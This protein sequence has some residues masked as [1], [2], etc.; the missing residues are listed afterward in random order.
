MD[1]LLAQFLIE[2]P[3][4]V[5]QGG[6]ALLALEKTPND[7]AQLDDAFRAVHTLKGSVGL[8][9]LPAMEAA[10]HA[11]EDVLSAIRE[12]R[13]M[14]DASTVG[15]LLAVLAQTERWIDALRGGGRLPADA[16]AVSAALVRRFADAEDEAGPTGAPT[17]SATPDWA[18]ALR[19]ALPESTSPGPLTALRYLPSADSYFSGDDP[20]ALLQAA[21]NLIHL[22]LGLRPEAAPG[23]PYDPFECRLVI[24]AVF[25]A[26]P[27]AV[28]AAFRFVPD[29]ISLVQI[30]APEPRQAEQAAVAIGRT[31]RIDADRIDALAALIDDLVAAKTRLG[32][33]AVRAG[34]GE[35]PEQI[36]E[37]IRAEYASIDRLVGQAHR[38]V[39]ALRMA[40]VAPLL[41]RLPLAVREMAQAAGKEVDFVLD[42]GTVEADRN[43]VEG[44]FE[45]LTHL[46]RNAVDHG[47]ELPEV[48]QRQGKPARA[49]ISLTAREAIGRLHIALRDDGR[50]IDPAAIRS[51]ALAR[52][53][54]EVDRLAEMSDAEAVEL[55]FLPGFSTAETVTALSGRGVGMDAVR[56]AVQR[57]GGRVAVSSQL[58]AGTLIELSL[59]LAVSLTKV[60]V[61]ADGGERYG[62]PVDQ[63]LE[64]IRLPA[65]NISP[66]RA[67]HAFN[68]RNQ[69]VPLMPLAS[70][71]GQ[72]AALRDG[73]QRAVVLRA[74]NQVIG[75]A[76][77]AIE[78]SL[79]LAV[80]P[81]GGL[82]V[83]MP[84]LAGSTVLSDG[85]VLMVLDP[86]ALIK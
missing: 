63:V 52:G 84:G 74:G 80:R 59:P 31:V 15:H 10:L 19:E 35:A 39:M 26:A 49:T 12:G 69:T 66:I 20:I 65:S 41:R 81:L 23:Q 11:A 2:G 71:T 48:R 34:A 25:A 44:L 3:E 54:A 8:F 61:V 47:V 67:G 18:L 22:A 77:E 13:R 56:A 21:P 30:E 50:G 68:W 33:V 78:D 24:E 14:P 76:I 58:G 60:L 27:D 51:R 73:D 55:I 36:A 16:Q 75:L 32:G 79:D 72:S 46:L 45:P 86:E 1:E 7:R 38:R 64:S 17:R 4:L 5:Q 43:T 37:A 70:L 62:I 85:A 9:D 29:Q 83:G 57:L 42:A 40:P 6:D 53:L 82:L 28:K